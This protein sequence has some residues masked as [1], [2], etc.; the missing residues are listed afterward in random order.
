LA[1][2]QIPAVQER[3]DAALPQRL[4]DRLDRRGPA[5]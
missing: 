1:G 4:R 5:L 2:S 3:I